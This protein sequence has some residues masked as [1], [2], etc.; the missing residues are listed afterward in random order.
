MNYRILFFK[1]KKMPKKTK[2]ANYL[3]L[4]LHI[5]CLKVLLLMWSNFSAAL[6]LYIL[7]YFMIPCTYNHGNSFHT[8]NNISENEIN[9]CHLSLFFFLLAQTQVFCYH[10]GKQKSERNKIK[11]T[12]CE[13]SVQNPT[14]IPHCLQKS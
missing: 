10:W 2:H 1:K 12:T 11:D 9:Y 14:P 8:W 4:Q 7:I 13:Y 5:C 3:D 6:L